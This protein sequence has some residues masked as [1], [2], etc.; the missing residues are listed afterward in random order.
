VTPSGGQTPDRTAVVTGRVISGAA[1]E[2]ASKPPAGGVMPPAG[3][4][5]PDLAGRSPAAERS[6]PGPDF[7]GPDVHGPDAHVRGVDVVARCSEPGGR[8]GGNPDAAVGAVGTSGDSAGGRTVLPARSPL[9]TG[10]A[11]A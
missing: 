2:P 9:T 1:H 11:R 3:A 7:D 5:G 8:S 10:W 4:G 6:G